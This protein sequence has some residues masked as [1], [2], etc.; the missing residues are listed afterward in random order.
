MARTERHLTRDD[1]DLVRD[2]DEIVVNH[3]RDRDPVVV[4]DAD[5]DRM[6]RDPDVRRRIVQEELAATLPRI[7]CPIL[8]MTSPNDHVVAPSAS[9]YLAANVS[10]PVERVTLARSY[11]VATLDYDKDLIEERAIEFARKVTAS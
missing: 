1:D 7:A 4:H 5:G 11:H 10:G 2:R 3:D 9:D 6:L 8:L